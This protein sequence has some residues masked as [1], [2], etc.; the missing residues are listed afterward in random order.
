M[1]SVSLGRVSNVV[2]FSGK[3]QAKEV[4]YLS[5]PVLHRTK[6]L[7][8]PTVRDAKA[9]DPALTLDMTGFK[10]PRNTCFLATV[11]IPLADGRTRVVRCNSPGRDEV[12]YAVGAD[13]FAGYAAGRPIQIWMYV[14][15]HGTWCW[16]HR[17]EAYQGKPL[18]V[19]FD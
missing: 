11:Y 10:V 17:T 13:A 3:P 14:S 7:E 8:H 18:V 15:D 2:I 16:W 19:R 5:S 1:S 9:A 6:L 12:G 4:L